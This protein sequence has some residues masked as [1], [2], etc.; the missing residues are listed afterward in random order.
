MIEFTNTIVATLIISVAIAACVAY[1][2]HKKNQFW[3]MEREFQGDYRE[4]RRKQD[5]LEM[6]KALEDLRGDENN[7]KGE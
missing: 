2:R 5:Y 4:W 1:T 7:S 3:R 6:Q